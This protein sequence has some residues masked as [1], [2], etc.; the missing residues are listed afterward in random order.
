MLQAAYGVFD[1]DNMLRQALADSLRDA[2]TAYVFY[3]RS[4]ICI[5]Y[6]EH[7]QATYENNYNTCSLQ[8]KYHN[9][10]GRNEANIFHQDGH[11]E[12]NQLNNR[13]IDLRTRLKL[14]FHVCTRARA[15]H[16]Q[17]HA[18]D[19]HTHIICMSVARE[20]NPSSYNDCQK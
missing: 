20:N 17:S 3:T 1:T 4:H 10:H 12:I 8:H 14:D 15:H 7:I 9:G 18:F 2:E 5:S 16:H 13:Q 6:I 11:I 19:L